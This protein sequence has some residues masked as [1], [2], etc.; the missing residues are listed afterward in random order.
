MEQLVNGPILLP[1]KG[2]G[3]LDDSYVAWGDKG[4]IGMI[5]AKLVNSLNYDALAEKYRAHYVFLE[6][7]RELNLYERLLQRLASNEFPELL[8]KLDKKIW[9]D[10]YIRMKFF[11]IGI[12]RGFATPL[13]PHHRTY[14]S[15]Y[16][17]SES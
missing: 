10:D 9:E 11:I 4:H 12:G 5:L 13:L 8:A 6:K 14:G 17:G 1:Y 15:V 2:Y 3:F 16:G 7:E